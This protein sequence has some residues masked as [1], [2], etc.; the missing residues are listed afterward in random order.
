MAN[1]QKLSIDIGLMSQSCRAE[2]SLIA[3][4]YEST[5][6]AVLFA[7]LVRELS[8]RSVDRLTLT[9]EPKRDSEL[10]HRS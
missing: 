5:E 8:R 6:S 10:I 3:K 9:K 1:S 2:L 7:I 4:E